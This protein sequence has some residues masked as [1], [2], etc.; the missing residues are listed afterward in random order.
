MQW[1]HNNHHHHHHHLSLNTPKGLLMRVCEG[2]TT[3]SDGGS[4]LSFVIVIGIGIVIVIVQ[5]TWIDTR[6]LVGCCWSRVIVIVIGIGIVIF[7]YKIP[8]PI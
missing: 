6:Y 8:G 2:R 3:S 4:G 5:D 7:R 1:G